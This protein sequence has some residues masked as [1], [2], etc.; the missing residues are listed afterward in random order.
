MS[1]D[2]IGRA[3]CHT[4]ALVASVIPQ[5]SEAAASTSSMWCALPDCDKIRDQGQFLGGRMLWILSMIA[6]IFVAELPVKASKA[7]KRSSSPAQCFS[8]NLICA[9]VALVATD[10]APTRAFFCLFLD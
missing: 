10:A 9:P 7:T 1:L 3:R 6:P 4:A 8:Q 2:R 5:Y